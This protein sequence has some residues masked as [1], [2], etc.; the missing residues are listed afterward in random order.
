MVIVAPWQGLDLSESLVAQGALLLAT[1]F[2]GL[3]LGYMRRFVPPGTISPLMMCFLFVG[4]GAVIMLA[5]TPAIAMSPVQLNG[6]IVASLVI[7]GCMGTG[8]VY[9]WNQNVLEA[10]GP[11]RTATLTYLSPVVGVVL[12]ILVLGEQLHWHEPV[13]ALI[14]LLGIMLAQRRLR[15]SAL[16]SSD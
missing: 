8:I 5:L 7:L 16:S 15:R 14:V 3:S 9:I 11:T 12:G 10:W 6:W 13:G 2:Y 1:A 4:I